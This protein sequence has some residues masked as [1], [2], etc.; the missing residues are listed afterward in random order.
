MYQNE[1]ENVQ[2]WEARVRHCA[3]YCEYDTFE[4]QAIRDRFIA[5]LQAKLNNNGHRDREGNIVLM[6]TVAEVA[7][8]PETSM[9]TKRLMRLARSDQ[10]QVNWTRTNNNWKA[11]NSGNSKGRERSRTTPSSSTIQSADPAKQSECKY[12]GFAPGHSRDKC[13]VVQMKYIC[14]RCGKGKHIA[15]KCMSTKPKPRNVHATDT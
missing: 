2:P 6:R 9:D 4:D 14:G 12:C 8:N 10:E 15:R 11:N 1:R 7:N 13:R 3:A 5:G